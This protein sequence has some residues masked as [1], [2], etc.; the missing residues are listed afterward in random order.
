MSL[1]LAA[2]LVTRHA[3]ASMSKCEAWSAIGAVVGVILFVRGFQ[4]LRFKQLILNTPESR[5][6]GAAMGLVEVS[7]TTK[8]DFT[9]PAGI[10]G[11]A[12]YYYRAVA[13]QLRES[14]RNRQWT[15]VASESFYVPFSIEDSTGRLL[16]EPQGADFDLQCNFKDEFDMSLLSGDRSML[17]EN[18]ARFLVRNGVG[19]TQSTRVE[20]HCVKPDSPLFI[21]G[22]LGQNLNRIPST[23]GAHVGGGTS[24]SAQLSFLGVS[25]KP[26]QWLGRTS[27][28]SSNVSNRTTSSLP[29][30]A[31]SPVG[32]ARTPS[33]ARASVWSE[34]SMDEA[35]I[36]GKTASPSQTAARP[37]TS[38]PVATADPDDRSTLTVP[39][40]PVSAR[41]DL[42]PSVSIGRSAGHDPFLISWRNQHEVVRSL[43]WKSVA[44]IWGGPAL[45]LICLYFLAMCLGG[46]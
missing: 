1:A 10:T 32:S 36:R 3:S 38:A 41:Y 4:M 45:S 8:G 42:N 33:P 30:P 11:E 2:L 46:L 9:L 14:G 22:T 40:A 43:A 7:G 20:E 31:V 12:C 37:T 13:W 35:M 39:E 17:P 28:T 18:V 5:I 19:F 15:Q 44:C 21:V 16:V 24:L 23:P 27:G 25:V 29:L 6:R 34:V 26:L